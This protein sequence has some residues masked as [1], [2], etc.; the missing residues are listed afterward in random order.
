MSDCLK[1]GETMNRTTYLAVGCLALSFVFF[2][3]Q[4]CGGREEPP[5]Q[6]VLAPSDSQIK[7]EQERSPSVE[8]TAEVPPSVPPVEAEVETEAEAESEPVAA[9]VIETEAPG[10]DDEIIIENQG[11]VNDRRKPVKLSHEKHSEEYGIACNSC[12]HVYKE[13]RNVWKEGDSVERCSVCHDPEEDKDNVIK[14][15]SAFHNKCR[16]CH[17]E[18]SQ[19]GKEAPYKKCTDC[20]G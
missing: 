2:P 13:G 18:I 6:E 12:H 1:K 9:P 3:L 4:G 10:S 17:K 11:Y 8:V 20:H 16:N 19:E 5:Q 7:E 14:L 15:Q